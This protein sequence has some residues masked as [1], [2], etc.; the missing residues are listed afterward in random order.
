MC[1]AAFL[2]AAAFSGCL[3]W[4][5]AAPIFEKFFLGQTRRC[6]ER[7]PRE[8]S[9]DRALFVTS[10][11]H[12]SL[13]TPRVFPPDGVTGRVGIPAKPNTK[14]GMIPNGIPG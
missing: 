11:L 8:N 9:A 3:F 10:R 5:P 13:P 7:V 1:G 14:S 12:G 2:A 4:G 6:E